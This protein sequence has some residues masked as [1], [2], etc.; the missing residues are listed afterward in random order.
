MPCATHNV[1]GDWNAST[2]PG[3]GGPGSGWRAM[4]ASGRPRFVLRRTTVRPDSP[5][6]RPSR[7][8][9][10]S[11]LRDLEA[12]GVIAR[13]IYSQHPPGYE[14]HLTRAGRDLLP[15]LFALR[16]WGAAHTAQPVSQLLHRC[17]RPRGQPGAPAARDHRLPRLRGAGPRGRRH[18]GSAAGLTRARLPQVLRPHLRLVSNRRG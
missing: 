14:S 7:N 5:G 12:A 16:E 8:I 1:A 10:A 18:R 2:V 11:R 9:L 13:S 4:V 6:D 15:V 3:G 17:D